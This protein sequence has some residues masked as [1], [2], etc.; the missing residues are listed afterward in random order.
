MYS[1]GL[2]ETSNY[3]SQHN[4]MIVVMSISFSPIRVHQNNQTNYQQLSFSHLYFMCFGIMSVLQTSLV[5]TKLGQA[6]TTLS[7]LFQKNH[8]FKVIEVH[9]ITVTYLKMHLR[10][11]E[12]LIVK[13]LTSGGKFETDNPF[14]SVPF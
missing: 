4:G 3:W 14:L 10:S 5:D 12:G 8:T 6:L 7:T 9:I 1:A 11:N 2:I 13:H